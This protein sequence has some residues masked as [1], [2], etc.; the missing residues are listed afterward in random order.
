MRWYHNLKQQKL[1]SLSLL[2][3]TLS[4]GILI[5][6]LVSGSV[7]A[8]KGQAAAPDAT[9][10]TIPPATASPNEFTKL[11]K[12]V[13]PAVVNITAEVTAKAPTARRRTVQPEEDEEGGDEMEMFRRFFGRQGQ[14]APNAR[15]RP[16][17]AT[18][19][20]FIVDKAGYIVTNFH[21][22][23]KADSIKVKLSGDD[24]DYKAKVIGTDWE[25]D[26]A[27][28]HIDAGHPLPALKIGNSDA[29]QVGDW[30]VA[31]G[32][33]FGLAAT[34]TA[35]IISATG[36]DLPSAEQFQRFIQT[37]AAI[38]PGNSGGPLVNIH[39]EVIGVN[40]AIATQSGGYQGIG[41]ALPANQMV[42]VYNSIIQ[43]GRAKRG[44]IGISWNK[45][46]KPEVLKA[47][48][49]TNGVLVTAVTPKAPADKAGLRAEDI[50]IAINGKSIKNGDELV[51]VVAETPVD[52]SL[53]ITV[54]RSG[55]RMDFT[56]VVQD[57]N[58]VFKDD[59]RFARHREEVEIPTK[60]EGT[61]AKFGISI[62][63]MTPQEKEPLKL[64]DERGV[65]VTR[66]E[67]GSFAAEIGIQERDV[68][69]SVNRQ[70]VTS[71]DDLR[72]VQSTLKPGDAV[73]FRVARAAP[74]APNRKGGEPIFQ[75][76]F[77]AGT[78][79]DKE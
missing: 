19:S 65:F 32:S 55:K 45:Y 62:R 1:L 48:G 29:V 38:N 70:P 49:V 68:I 35:G 36:R 22:V 3:F 57:R 61:P 64:G 5:G 8:A 47:A 43:Y 21:V 51:G 24:R 34:V 75:T 26:I 28:I 23:E 4:V 77:A 58:E 71:L 52:S 9:P 17:E 78:L 76:F 7:S 18:G 66:V 53:K 72:R 56:V 44:S 6:T 74:A 67:E 41:F 27:V 12:Q 39:G 33:P 54:D 15:P 50:I 79:P 42:K 59:E 16:R 73:A 10:L 20:G 11:A 30:S 13:E 25:S 2:V 14:G 63:A 40:T 69:I 37:D 46:E 31:I 60:T